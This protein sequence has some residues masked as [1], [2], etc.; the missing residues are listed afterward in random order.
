MK[1]LQ[2]FTMREI[3]AAGINIYTIN[4]NKWKA[5]PTEIQEQIMEAGSLHP[6]VLPRRYMMVYGICDENT[7]RVR[8]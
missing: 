1:L 6:C 4:L 3:W 7:K 5:L 8:L 2:I